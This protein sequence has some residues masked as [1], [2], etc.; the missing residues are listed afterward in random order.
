[1]K[2]KTLLTIFIICFVASAVLSFIPPEEACGGVQTGCYAVN[3]S[4]YENTIGIKNSYF[5]LIAFGTL[6][7]LTGSQMKK[8]RKKKQTLINLGVIAGSLFALYYLYLQA[9]VIKAFCK[10]C[11]V[12]DSG[13]LLSL[14]IVFTWRPK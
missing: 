2:N 11:L 4:G 12:V 1:M 9:F 3:N 13:I 6:I 10:Y 14:I 7:F 5:G 8:P